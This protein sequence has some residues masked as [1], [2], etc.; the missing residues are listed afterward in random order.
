MF[1]MFA[2]TRVRAHACASGRNGRVPGFSIGAEALIAAPVAQQG[3][4]RTGVCAG[5]VVSCYPRPVRRWG[6]WIR[7][8]YALCLGGATV[9]HVRAALSRGWL[10]EQLPLA[11]AL[12]WDSLTFLDPLAAVLL[13]VRPRLGIALTVAIIVSDVAHNLWLMA[14]YPLSGSFIA[15]VTS[16]G[17]MLSQIAFFLFVAATAPLAWRECKLV[18][19]SRP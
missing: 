6:F 11:T 1:P 4:C 17:F 12:Y 19:S 3:R 13:F 7:I 10:P 8:V 2:V 14:A 9:N 16:S 18:S 5:S 15:D